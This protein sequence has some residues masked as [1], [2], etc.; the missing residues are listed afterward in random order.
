MLV[1]PALY[2]DVN[3]MAPN[4]I[5]CWDLWLTIVALGSATSLSHVVVWARLPSFPY[6]TVPPSASTT[7]GLSVSWTSGCLHLFAWCGHLQSSIWNKCLEVGPPGHREGECVFTRNCTR[8]S[9]GV[10]PPLL[11]FCS[12][13]LLAGPPPGFQGSP[14]LRGTFKSSSTTG[15]PTSGLAYLP[16]TSL[17]SF[18]LN[19]TFQ[20]Y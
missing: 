3:G 10:H 8:L 19:L 2:L 20:P 11:G 4:A 1:L 12:L 17:A 14:Y 9:R 7:A 6:Y 18:P 16:A 5:S 15:P 13:L